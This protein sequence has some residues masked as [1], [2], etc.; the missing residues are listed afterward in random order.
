ML[1]IL[2]TTFAVFASVS[3]ANAGTLSGRVSFAGAPPERHTIMMTG[4]PACDRLHPKGRPS[5]VTLVDAKGGLANVLV[6]VRSGLPKKYVA[7]A[8]TGTAQIDQEGCLFRP[9]VLGVRTGQEIRIGNSDPT[10]HNV[11][12]RAA[13]NT[14]FNNAMPGAGQVLHKSFDRAEV[15]VKLKCDIHPW[16]AAYVGVFDHPFFAVTA[17]DGSFTIPGIPEGDEY[18]VEAWHEALGTQSAKVE[19]EDDGEARLEFSFAGN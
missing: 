2:V 8:P 5:E 13:N 17:A 9:R 19:I 15:A 3:F 7:P 14:P 10:L 1:A 16:M 12:A 18:V 6:Y 11:N 4:D